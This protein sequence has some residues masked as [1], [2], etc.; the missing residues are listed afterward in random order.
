MSVLNFSPTAVAATEG[1]MACI[2]DNA[3]CSHLL[4]N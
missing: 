1:E 4:W 2:N 3:T